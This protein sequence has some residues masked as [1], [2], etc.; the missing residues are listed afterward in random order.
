MGATYRVAVRDDLSVEDVNVD[1][2]VCDLNAVYELA[3]VDK[4]DAGRRVRVRVLSDD[5]RAPP[6]CPLWQDDLV[7]KPP[8]NLYRVPRE[9][10]GRREC[11]GRDGELCVRVDWAKRE[12]L[13]GC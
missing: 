3:E 6:F 11:D 4:S 12:R 7:C 5:I 1:V 10:E 13:A 2:A 9:T 8:C